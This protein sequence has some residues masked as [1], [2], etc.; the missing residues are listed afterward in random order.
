M[1]GDGGLN[2]DIGDQGKKGEKV[3]ILPLPAMHA[4]NCTCHMH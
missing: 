2:G 1:E 4:L 3:Y